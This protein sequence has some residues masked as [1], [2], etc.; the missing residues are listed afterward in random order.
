MK[1]SDYSNLFKDEL[2]KLNLLFYQ[3]ERI[4]CIT[5][6]EIYTYLKKNNI[7]PGYYISPWFITLFTDAFIDDPKDNNKEVIMKI[8]DTFII[9]GWKGIIRVGMSLIKNNE[10]KIMNT[11][12][13]E[14]LNYLTCE[15]IKTKY[16]DKNNSAEIMKA[17]LKYKING[18]M[19]A[20]TESQY[21]MKKS[22]TK[23]E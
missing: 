2:A 9:G 22:L 1:D 20:D 19:L 13:E 23:L 10:S 4:M 6:P 7:T 5:F 11:P 15:I 12:I 21:M 14:L 17:Y 16:F 18:E 8:I 3:F